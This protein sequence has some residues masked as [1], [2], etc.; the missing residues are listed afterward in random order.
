MIQRT[1]WN[2]D[3]VVTVLVT[4]FLASIF[5]GDIYFGVT[6]PL[7]CLL[8]FPLG[9]LALWYV[10]PRVFLP[11]P[12]TWPLLG[13]LLIPIF[14]TGIGRPPSRFDLG[15]YLPIVYAAVSYQ[16]LSFLPVRQEVVRVGILIGTVA[17]AGLTLWSILFVGPNQQYIPGQ[18]PSI[19]ETHFSEII[20]SLPDTELT[21][22]QATEP[23]NIAGGAAVQE[24]DDQTTLEF[25]RY[26]QTVKTPLGASNYLAVFFMFGFSVALFTRHFAVALLSAAFIFLTMS[27]FGVIFTVIPIITFAAAKI[28]QSPRRQI[29]IGACILIIAG[30]TVSAYVS[31]L[32]LPGLQSMQARYDIAQ[33]AFTPISE[34]PIFGQPRSRVV[35]DLQYP[36]NWHPHNFILWL[37]SLGGVV[38]LVLYCSYLCVISRNLW[39]LRH[40]QMWMGVIVGFATLLLWGLFE[41]IFLSPAWEILLAA[42][43]AVAFRNAE[44]AKTRRHHNE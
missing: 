25:Y 16:I 37:L 39:E 5:Y 20:T 43:A 17:L 19:T 24:I 8:L 38:G 4:A 31:G 10:G 41:I 42:C 18:D 3:N 36:A 22:N 9:C 21:G 29:I 44:Q 14:Q 6:I 15:S 7:A 2:Y 34:S 11:R 27:R 40:K 35:T 13:F 32:P 30:A 26:K 1:Q 12:A 28:W 23:R 33:S